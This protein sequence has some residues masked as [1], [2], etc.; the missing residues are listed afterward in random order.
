[1]NNRVA[2]VT[3]GSRGIGREVAKRLASDGFSVVVGY[4]GNAE[5]AAATVKEIATAGGSAVA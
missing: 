5:E 2:V 1:M 3:G 4:A